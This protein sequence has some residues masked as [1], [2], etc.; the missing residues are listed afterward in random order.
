MAKLTLNDVTNLRDFTTAETTINNNWAA[1]ETAVE[2]TLS[3]DGTSP[4]QMT[5]SLDMNS[6]QVINLPFPTSSNS[7]VRLRDVISLGTDVGIGVPDGGNTGDVL[8]KASDD[9]YAVEWIDLESSLKG[10]D[11]KAD[12]E[13]ATIEATT[14][15]IE[16]AGYSTIGDGGGARY[17]RSASEPTH[18]GKIESADGAWWELTEKEVCPEMFGGFDGTSCATAVQAA[19][20]YPGAFFV[21]LNG[22]YTI[23]TGLLISRPLTVTGHAPLVG[24]GG[25]TP[26]GF[27]GFRS[28]SLIHI[29]TVYGQ[30]ANDVTLQNFHVHGDGGRTGQPYDGIRI[31]LAGTSVSNGAITSGDATFTSAT[32]NFTSADIGKNIRIDGA[33][34]ASATLFTSIASINSPTSVEL[35]TT[36]STTVTG[37]YAYWV[38]VLINPR[39][40]GV[41]T[42][43]IHR[44]GVHAINN[45]NFYASDDFHFRGETASLRLEN[46]YWSDM[47]DH[48]IT[49]GSFSHGL[50]GLHHL[51]GGGLKTSNCK[52]TNSQYGYFAD[53]A[54]GISANL[55]INNW[56][57]EGPANAA[58]RIKP[59]I[60]GFVRADITNNTGIG[61]RFLQV[62][63]VSSGTMDMLTVTGN[64]Y[65]CT[66]AN[67]IIDIGKADHFV[68]SDNVLN[69]ES[70]A[71]IG[72]SIASAASNGRVLDNLIYNCTTDVSN[73]STTTYVRRFTSTGSTQN[74]PID[75][76]YAGSAASIVNTNDNAVVSVA[77]FEGDRASPANADSAYIQYKMANSSGAQTE[78]GRFT[79]GVSDVTASSEDGY[80]Q[81]AITAAG[82]PATKLFLNSAQLAPSSAGGLVLG[83]STTGWSGLYLAGSSSGDTRL[84]ASATASGTLTLPAATDT[85]VGKATTD[86]FTNKTVNLTSNTLTG[87]TAQFNTALSDNDF[88]TLAGSETLSNKTIASPVFSGTITGT[89]TIGGTPTF[90]ADVVTL[91]GSQTLTNKTLTTPIIAS[92]SNTGTLTLPTS[93]DTLVGRATTDTLT[94]KTLTSPV[95]GGTITGTVSSSSAISVTN[96]TDTSSG[97]TGSIN[98]AGGLGIAKALYVGT[99]I[100]MAGATG[101]FGPGSGGGQSVNFILSGGSGS[102]SPCYFQFNV[103]SASKWQFGLQTGA[104]NNDLSYYRGGSSVYALRISGTDDTVSVNATTASTATS[105]G[106]LVVA[107]GVG[108][109]GAINAGTFVKTGVT[110]VGALPAAGTK[111]RKYFV[112]DANATTFASVVAGGGANNV[113]VYDDGT[114]WRI[115]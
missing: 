5:A 44:Y 49:D 105:N 79:W 38:F 88:A 27:C 52:S 32:A 40:L 45:G 109:A 92:I 20:D 70:T 114:N 12:V 47:G 80:M 64:S 98:T 78:Y 39:L 96:T 29:L 99:T 95:F 26:E 110:T 72:I 23:D 37:A 43:P 69:G 62:D 106:A 115:G 87:T 84:N 9:D 46:P 93:T 53:W 30:D 14:D 56:S 25:N 33:G 89:Y 102:A 112:S 100:N 107:G 21:K 66:A 71:T 61:G 35:A 17:K 51:S 74:Y 97:S 75:I 77:S 36:A 113:P 76:Q 42:S 60:G 63:T 111:G 2:K 82:T 8:A 11:T 90:P 19:F 108:V 81:W 48:I 16:I 15:S 18:A 6:N 28:N 1:I 85:L 59:D 68:I 7:P 67:P 22:M 4:N 103:D 86:A 83:Q 31:G 101:A 57:I 10:F 13:A 73:S 3:R 65:Q 50:T 91:T 58:I 104:G 55:V 24:G 41:T 54:V 34:A 94:N